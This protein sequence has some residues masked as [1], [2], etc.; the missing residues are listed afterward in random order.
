VNIPTVLTV[1]GVDITPK[2]AP[3]TPVLTATVTNPVLGTGAGSGAT[4]AYFKV[5]RM[6]TGWAKFVF[7]S[8]GANR[9]LGTFIVSLPVPMATNGLP[10][11]SLLL[12]DAGINTYRGFVTVYGYGT[13]C[14]Y[15][16]ADDLNWSPVTDTAP[17]T[18]GADGDEIIVAF[19]YLAAL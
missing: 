3:Y 17:F 5:G 13:L 18:F 10:Y 9:G 19:G 11:G 7:G 12:L 4:G 14:M 15:A 8:S 2:E 6:V 1:G 16:S